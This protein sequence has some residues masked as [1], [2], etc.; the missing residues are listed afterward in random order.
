MMLCGRRAE[1]DLY[2][3]MDGIVHVQMGSGMYIL[4]SNM[5]W[6]WRILNMG[7]VLA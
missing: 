1:D 6:R 3:M 2:I 7:Y 5:A 4:I